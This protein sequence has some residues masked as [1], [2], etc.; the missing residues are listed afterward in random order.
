[1]EPEIEY[2]ISVYYRQPSPDF[3]Q[4]SVL[5]TKIFLK[6]IKHRLNLT[7]FWIVMDF[8]FYKMVGFSRVKRTLQHINHS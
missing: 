1:M 6:T 4:G 3:Q 2:P 5:L 7:T 8:Y